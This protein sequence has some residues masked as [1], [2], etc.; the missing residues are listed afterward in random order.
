[1]RT[2]A[3]IVAVARRGLLLVLALLAVLALS[4]RP[5]AANGAHPDAQT[6]YSDPAGPY[7]VQVDLAPYTGIVHVAVF[8][9]EMGSGVAVTDLAVTVAARPAGDGWVERPAP[10]G[11]LTARRVAAKE[12]GVDLVVESPGLWTFAIGLDGAPGTA[13]VE[14]EVPLTKPASLAGLLP[15][16][17][18][19]ALVAL[20]VPVF[21]LRR[22]YRGLRERRTRPD[23]F[24]D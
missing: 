13:A 14:L 17:V 1:M 21:L 23:F 3:S 6:Y 18:L 4:D 5:A 2:R 12:F 22:Y 10:V 15:A 16:I 8:A 7:F 24:E 19:I 9:S 11:P 20:V